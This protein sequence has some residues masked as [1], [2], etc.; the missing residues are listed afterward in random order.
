MV[1]E[2]LMSEGQDSFQWYVVCVTAGAERKVKQ[3]IEE[4]SCKAG[5][6]N[7]FAEI[8]I[9]SVPVTE[10]RRGNK[11]VVEKKIMPG[12][13]FVHMDMSDKAARLIEDIP[14]VFR[15]L[16]GNKPNVVKLEEIARIREA[17][18]NQAQTAR[19]DSVF[20]VG[21]MVQIL[22]GPFESFKGQID[23]VNEKDSKVVVVV[24]I[25]GNDTRIT[26]SMDHIKRA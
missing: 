16:G 10:M 26:L 18:E 1:S 25:F 3:T 15:F 2:V 8:L 7:S 23:S 4:Q 21:D 12:Y 24:S 19:S 5:L 14:E 11:I 13:L 6:E 9:P 22:E 17:I 20:E